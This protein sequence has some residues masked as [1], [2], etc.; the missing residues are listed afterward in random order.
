MF[1]NNRFL[2]IFILAVFAFIFAFAV[3]CTDNGVTPDDV[4]PLVPTQ[5]TLKVKVAKVQINSDL[6]IT[7]AITPATAQGDDI[8]VE[9]SNNLVTYAKQGNNTIILTAG[10]KDG[11]VKITVK[12]SNGI[13]ASKTIKVQIEAVES[14]PDLNGYDIKIA[15]A[16]HALGEYDVRLTKDTQ[17]KYGY[18]NG[19][20]RDFKIQAWDDV[21][22][23]Y[24]CTISVVAY[25]SDAP[26]G[27]SR[28]N[29]ILTQAQQDSPE[30]DFY[31]VE[32][33]CIPGFVAGNAVVDLTDWYSQY[34]KNLM[35]EMAVSVCS[36]KNRI[37][38]ICPNDIKVENLIG[39]NLN[40]FYQI[41]EQDPSL[42]EPAQMYLD[43]NWNYNTFKEFVIKAQ[44]ALNTIN[45]TSDNYYVL[46]GYGTYYWLGMVNAAGIK[47]L[48]TTQ[49]KANLTLET[50]AKAA[51]VLQE[52][53]AMGAM[54]PAFQIDGSVATWNAG[55][56]L[57]NTANF[58]F[59]NASD[60]WSKTLWGEGDK[61]MYGF[62][63]FPTSP[64]S[65]KT[66][67]GTT[68]DGFMVMASGRDWAYKGFGE[69]CTAENVYR[70]FMDYHILSKQ[71]YKESENYNYI[72]DLTATAASK[73][74]SE[75]SVQA[76]VRLTAGKLQEDGT[77][78]D[79]LKDVG[80]YDPFV[81]ENNVASPDAGSGSFGAAVNTFI[82]GGDA[83]AQWVDAVGSFQSQIEKSLVDVYG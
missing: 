52:I 35:N 7:Y 44:N 15:Q 67:I 58:W 11:T 3:G 73:F 61:T 54:D 18:Y 5:I 14:Y 4:N 74:G 26:W 65:D 60:R 40:L 33:F 83:S 38:A 34:G 29:Y 81:N 32:S 31:I 70:A 45:Q 13:T 53:Y 51:Q 24:N 66:Y 50:E 8:S 21:E 1:K 76:F 6:K 46:S 69:E 79:G 75:A 36:Y 49:L 9:L 30:Y 22:D 71:Y 55:H 56:S 47:I 10:D 82:K 42:V 80:F 57:F 72:E 68:A 41:K 25:P 16:E 12:T 17:D 63:P 20:D 28:W 77:Y 59:I 37:Y 48:D 27:P 19:Q 23:N 2:K 62:V 64:D 78:V 43:G 39:M